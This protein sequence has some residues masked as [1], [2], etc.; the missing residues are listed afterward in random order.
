M[1]RYKEMIRIQVGQTGAEK[2]LKYH[3]T[4]AY[5]NAELVNAFAS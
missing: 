2:S 5:G 1:Y 4:S 3:F